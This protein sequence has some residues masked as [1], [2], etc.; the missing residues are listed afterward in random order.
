VTRDLVDYTSALEVVKD[1]GVV[2]V[3]PVDLELARR[4]DE[5]YSWV[6]NDVGS[7]RGE[8]S[9]IIGFA[10]D[11][12]AVET[13]TRT[14]LSSTPTHFRLH[15]QLDAYECDERVFAHSWRLTIPRDQV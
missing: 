5:R 11:G 6:G 10:R 1:L 7:V 14:V 3:D 15:A 12:W 8:V 9:W 4:S 13:H 2:R